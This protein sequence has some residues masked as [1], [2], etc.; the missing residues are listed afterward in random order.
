MLSTAPAAATLRHLLHWASGPA[1]THLRCCHHKLITLPC[2]R[3]PAA[4]VKRGR[5][6]GQGRGPAAHAAGACKVALH[7]RLRHVGWRWNRRRAGWAVARVRQQQAGQ[8]GTQACSVRSRPC[9]SER[10]W[11]AHCA[12]WVALPLAAGSA[13]SCGAGGRWCP[14]PL[15]P[16]STSPRVG[17][18][19]GHRCR[20]S[21]RHTRL[22][23][24]SCTHIHGTAGGGHI[25]GGSQ[26]SAKGR[27]R[28]ILVRL[29]ALLSPQQVWGR[30]RPLRQVCRPACPTI[31]GP[32]QGDPR[33][34]RRRPHSPPCP[35]PGT[36]WRLAGGSE[37]TGP[38]ASHLVG[39]GGATRSWAA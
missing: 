28:A 25:N 24:V 3:Q 10:T 35:A 17:F 7:A 37:Q 6:G 23:I 38:P 18:S 27:A 11:P 33:Q 8:A 13:P 19:Y 21:L 32:R 36:P 22:K 20:P 12:W 30:R 34:R 31:T 39:E 2:S 16:L 14:P 5:Q 1:G 26:R 4:P 15:P 9:C 29:P